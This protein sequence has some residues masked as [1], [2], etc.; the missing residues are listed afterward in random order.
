MK[1]VSVGLVIAIVLALLVV[2]VAYAGGA[3]KLGM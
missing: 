3:V 2:F 1:K